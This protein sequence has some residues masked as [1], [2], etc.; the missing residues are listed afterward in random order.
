MRKEVGLAPKSDAPG[1]F[2]DQGNNYLPRS[3]APR[4]RDSIN[5]SGHVIWAFLTVFGAGSKIRPIKYL[6][7][8]CN[9]QLK[10][11]RGGCAKMI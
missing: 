7:I 4:V 9:Y 6:K 1:C 8:R 10:L 3:A 2:P 11:I 5:R